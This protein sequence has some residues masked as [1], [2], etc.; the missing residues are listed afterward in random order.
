[1]EFSEED[2]A[3]ILY[4]YDRVTKE[5]THMFDYYWVVGTGL[6]AN[7][8]LVQPPIQQKEGFTKVFNGESWDY[9]ED[10]RG[11]VVYAQANPNLVKR[12]TAIGAI[13]FGYTDK[14]PESEYC[15]WDG[16]AWVDLRSP[17][18]VA[19]DLAKTLPALTR[20][21]FKLVLLD[22]NL[23][24]QVELVLSSIEDP[25][26]KA[27]FNIEYTE[28][29]TFERLNPSVIAMCSLLGFTDEQ[30]NDLWTQALTY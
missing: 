9:V 22:Y 25:A 3:V 15:S 29:T 30:L 14:V 24:D 20:R 26:V 12:M 28:S 11:K 18:Q 13:D 1:M 17:E 7:S 10:H 6:A 19:S 4:G 27:R 23:L 8:T 5:Y 2:R 21:Q 16:T